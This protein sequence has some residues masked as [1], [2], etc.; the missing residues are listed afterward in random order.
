M[1]KKHGVSEE[2]EAENASGSDFSV[3]DENDDKIKDE[4]D[5]KVKDENDDEVKDENDDRYQQMMPPQISSFGA[6]ENSRTTVT[7]C[8]RSSGST[9]ELAHHP[10]EFDPERS[11]Q[12]NNELYNFTLTV[13][14][15][16]WQLLHPSSPKPRHS[17]TQALFKRRFVELS[18]LFSQVS[19]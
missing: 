3:K 7:S 2:A 4:N 15:W 17:S 16:E 9:D 11:R 8:R 14:S 12:I 18:G 5:D 1:R 6:V 10:D 13:C 19:A